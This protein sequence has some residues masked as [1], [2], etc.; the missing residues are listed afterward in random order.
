M[1]NPPVVLKEQLNFNRP[2][3]TDFSLVER[4]I[5]QALDLERLDFQPTAPYESDWDIA[6]ETYQTEILHKSTT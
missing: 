4:G 2:N 5:L 6:E 3:P 1:S